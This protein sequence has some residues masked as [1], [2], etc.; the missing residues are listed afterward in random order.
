MSLP[1]FL[2]TAWPF[3][4]STSPNPM[5]SSSRS[6]RTWAASWTETEGEELGGVQPHIRLICC[7]PHTSAN[8]K[9]KHISSSIYI[10]KPTA[11]QSPFQKQKL[12]IAALHFL[13][14]EWNRS[15]QLT[16][17]EEHGQQGFQKN[18][19]GRTW[20][21]YVK[22]KRRC[23]QVWWKAE[24]VT[25]CRSKAV[26]HIVSIHLDVSLYLGANAN[27]PKLD[28]IN[29]LQS[30]KG[31]DASCCESQALCSSS[32]SSA[33]KAQITCDVYIT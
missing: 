28:S 21:N 13:K 32:Q 6:S 7:S 11:F 16:A 10:S 25:I 9:L 2:A 23:Q 29:N 5:S 31:D 17:W 4:S 14:S 20:A 24:E 27:N 19:G 33:A 18:K 22:W 12:W 30:L 3:F 15:Q 26:Q 8:L 1:S